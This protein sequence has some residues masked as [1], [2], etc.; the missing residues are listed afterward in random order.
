M[1]QLVEALLTD[2]IS[3]ARHPY[4]N[5]VMQHLLEHGSNDQRS[6]LI[7]ML[8]QHA[9]V[10][11]ADEYACA[12]I[13]KAMARGQRQDQ[14]ALARALAKVPETLSFMARTRHGHVAARLVRLIP[15][16]R[17]A[18]NHFEHTEKEA[19]PKRRFGTPKLKI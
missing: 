12:V 4:G 8:E 6:T 3:T 19:R 15:K 18:Q 9:P 2:A 11:A 16:T 1:S 10:V 5:Y 14:M 7:R 17:F 13:G